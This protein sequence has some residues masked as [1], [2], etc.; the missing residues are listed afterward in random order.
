MQEMKELLGRTADVSKAMSVDK[1]LAEHITTIVN[2]DWNESNTVGGAVAKLKLSGKNA[3][4]A[5]CLGRIV[6]KNKW[7]D[8]KR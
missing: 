1:E 4:K 6:E 5:Y 7:E 8:F 3:Y 2:A